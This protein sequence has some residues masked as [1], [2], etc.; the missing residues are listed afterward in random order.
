[1]TSPLPRV[2]STTE[3]RRRGS[4]GP[5]A[6]EPHTVARNSQTYKS[7]HKRTPAVRCPAR[8]PRC[9]D[10]GESMRPAVFLDRDDTLIRCR[11]VTGDGDL[12]DPDLV[13]LLPGV[14]DGC[15]ALKEAGFALVVITNQGGVARGKY[16]LAAVD[17]VN[18][19]LN[20][21]LDGAIDLFRCCP[22]HPKGK[23]EEYTREHPWRKPAPGM[24]LDAAQELGLDCSQSWVIGD[25]ARD[26]QAGRAAGCR[27]I[28]VGS[29]SENSDDAIDHRAASFS[30]AVGFV[31]GSSQINS[32]TADLPHRLLVVMP[33]WVG[34]VVMATPALRS[35]RDRLP[36]AF[37]GGLVKP[38]VDDLLAGTDLFDELHVDSRAGVMGVKRAASKVRPPRYDAAVLMTN[39][40]STALLTRLA[41]ITRR[42][43]YGRDGR[44]MLLTE[45][46]QAPRRSSTE[47]FSQSTSQR[48]WAPNPACGHYLGLV[49]RLLNDETIALEP[50]ELALTGA[51]QNDANTILDRA[52]VGDGDSYIVLN[53]GGNN[54]AKRWPADR[55]AELA[56]TIENE[57]S[58][59][60]LIAGSPGERELAET[61][62]REAS[63]PTERALPT[64]SLS[65][66]SLKG[67]LERASLLVTNDT[68]PRHIAAAFGTPVVTLFGPTDPRW[69]TIPFDRET[70]LVADPTLPECEMAED[71]AERCRIDRIELASVLDAAINLLQNA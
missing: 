70:V 14:A 39:S 23:I 54:I 19:K 59:R 21:L 63:L 33:T 65:L 40:F 55:F 9:A 37:I 60:V 41:G 38:G 49:K 29:V 17:R 67:V 62:A 36:G 25:T 28:L 18:A 1:M 32:Q 42:I 47:P 24:I 45:S 6:S 56:R 10:Y 12:G 26:C 44:S 35:L 51:Q 66:G 16:D 2:C 71:H 5:L 68:G 7:N 30:Q 43:G 13:E 64:L 69:T 61:I 22:F 58:M 48:A 8:L 27:T 4:T 31:I 57:H 53:P 15:R 20:Q 34:D 52:G 46:L 11:S 3:L 50:M